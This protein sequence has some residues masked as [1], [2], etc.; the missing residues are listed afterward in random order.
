M[1]G[2]VTGES[3]ASPRG[4]VRASQ[5]VVLI[6]LPNQNNLLVGCLAGVVVVADPT[7]ECFVADAPNVNVMVAVLI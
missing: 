5:T 2:A 6:G 1:P 4:C 7:S 3:S